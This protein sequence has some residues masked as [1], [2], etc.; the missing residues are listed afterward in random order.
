M[1]T[2]GTTTT[3]SIR[4]PEGTD[5][6]DVHGDMQS[7]AESVETALD[8]FAAD[9]EGPGVSVTNNSLVRFDGTVGNTIQGSVA[10]LSDTGGLS[11]V[12]FITMAGA[13]STT[14]DSDAVSSVTGSITTAGGIGVAKNLHVGVDMSVDNVVTISGGSLFVDHPS[15]DS[16]IDVNSVG[17]Q[18]SGFTLQS[19]DTIRWTI[20]RDASTSDLVIHRSPSGSFIDSPFTI[21]LG[22][23]AVTLTDDLSVGGSL[24]V[25]ADATI[26]FDLTVTGETTVSTPI[27]DYHAATKKYIDDIAIGSSAGNVLGPGAATET[28]VTRFDGVT[29]KLLQ[30]SVVLIGDTGEVAGVSSLEASGLVTL[31][32]V[33]ESSSSITGS[34]TTVGG[35]GVGKS[36]FVGD[37]LDVTGEATFYSG[38]TVTEDD[39]YS[40]LD[41]YITVD[42]DISNESGVELQT[43][44]SPRWKIARNATS[45]EL[46]IERYPTGAYVGDAISLDIDTGDATFEADVTVGG[47]INA[48]STGAADPQVQWMDDGVV[49]WR[50]LSDTS[51]SHNY[52]LLRYSAGGSYQGDS[53]KFAAV[54]G[55]AE[56][57]ADVTV[58]GDVVVDQTPGTADGRLIIDVDP[59]A[60]G[61][62]QF[63]QDGVSIWQMRCNSDDSFTLLNSAAANSLSIA[64]ATSKIT[65]GGD[66]ELGS[67]G[68]TQSS[69]TGDPEGVVT[70]PVGSAFYRTDGGTSTSFYIKESGVG[71]TGWTAG[72]GAGG[73]MVPVAVSTT[74]T[75]DFFDA[76]V[77]A[78]S[79][80]FTITLPTPT[81]PGEQ[82][83]IKNS[84]TG[85]VTLEPTGA[86]TID[87]ETSIPLVQWDSIAVVSDGTDWII[88][89][90]DLSY[91][92]L[93]KS[94]LDG[95]T[96]LA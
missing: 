54:D 62:V 31:T 67:G 95:G 7:L 37:A 52:R 86:E 61:K 78:T 30:N 43:S 18:E 59:T 38:L 23:G 79:G 9:I 29:G 16:Y 25:T 63:N 45:E 19:N 40:V 80:T 50:A 74:Y 10:V 36:L 22:S 56:F 46:V 89:N 71:N 1:S 92:E 83:T 64:N 88:I 75:V 58:G 91:W 77:V 39:I 2:S 84:G 44:T 70:A 81:D 5:A 55:A 8:A 66:I 82:H 21:N 65:V 93:D 6:L 68:P 13:L 42:A 53:L 94:L 41:T 27:S 20:A 57:E 32:D 26:G 90:N 48:D 49:R 76:L 73:S 87:S 24:D 85:I 28:A 96:R 60:T 14:D 11:G 33:T 4:Y 69:G 47:A 15:S 34:L 72:G 35:I 51:T 12:T 17:G 3:Y